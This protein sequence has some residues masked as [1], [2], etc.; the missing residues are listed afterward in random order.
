VRLRAYLDTVEQ[1]F[2]SAL[3]SNRLLALHV[4]V[5]LRPG[6][7]LLRHNDLENYLTPLAQRLKTARLVSAS[8]S[9][10]ITGGTESRVELWGVQA[11]E[12]V[13]PGWLVVMPTGSPS[14]KVWKASLRDAL[15]QAGVAQ[16]RPGP[17]TMELSFRCSP[18]RR[19][20]IN[21]WKCAGDAL[22]PLLGEPDPRNAFNPADDRIVELA[23]HLDADE[24]MG[25]DVEIGLLC[26]PSAL[27]MEA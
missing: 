27:P 18:Q 26:G 2:A 3:N 6:T 12:V 7:D 20:W 25:N 9:K 10:S 23:L 5:R 1:A 22:G 19:N 15:R 13:E 17:V 11:A 8:A 16:E 4:D 24:N 14:T 21:L